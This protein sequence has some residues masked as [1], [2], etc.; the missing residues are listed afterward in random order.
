MRPTQQSGGLLCRE[1]RIETGSEHLVEFD[2]KEELYLVTVRRH[3][4]QSLRKLEQKLPWN[5]VSYIIKGSDF[6][7]SLLLCVESF[8]VTFEPQARPR[9]V[10]ESGRLFY[11]VPRWGREFL[12]SF[13]TKWIKVVRNSWQSYSQVILHKETPRMALPSAGFCVVSNLYKK[14]LRITKPLLILLI[15]Y[16]RATVF[17]HCVLGALFFADCAQ[18]TSGRVRVSRCPPYIPIRF[19]KRNQSQ[20]R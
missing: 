4:R 6:H 1:R 16:M 20:G 14:R 11:G 3:S 7:P 10:K 19:H 9:G 18:T 5:K 15:F 2:C 17:L 8:K 12:L 13:R